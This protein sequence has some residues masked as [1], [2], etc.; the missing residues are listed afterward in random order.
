MTVSGTG[1]DL[2]VKS[3]RRPRQPAALGC[4]AAPVRGLASL[5]AQRKRKK[6]AGC[7]EV[8]EGYMF[9]FFCCFFCHPVWEE[10]LRLGL[11]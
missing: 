11:L 1:W 7:T 6:E 8:T 2:K 3:I 5:S 4:A 9:C 10:A